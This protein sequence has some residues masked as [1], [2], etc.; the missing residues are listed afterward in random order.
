MMEEKDARYND[1]LNQYNENEKELRLNL[2]ELTK[3]NGELRKTF[4]EEVSLRIKLQEE[5][6]KNLKAHEEEVQ[7][8]LQFEGK[9]N[10][11]HSMHRDLQAKYER[12]LEDIHRLE[13]VNRAT[14]EKYDI[15]EAELI[16]LR[17]LKIEH[18]AKITYLDERIKNLITECAQK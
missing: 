1:E 14:K 9:L 5:M 2:D 6:F 15:C 11:L 17:S 10:G 7:L 16:Q 8:R 13:F 12:A 4:D 3:E 18:E